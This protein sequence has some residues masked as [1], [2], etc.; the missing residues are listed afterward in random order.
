VP[1]DP[2]T[3]MPSPDYTPGKTFSLI[4]VQINFVF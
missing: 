4:S 1:T 2:I 3:F